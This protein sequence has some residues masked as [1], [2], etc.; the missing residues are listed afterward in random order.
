MQIFI[1][2]ICSCSALAPIKI[3][4]CVF[5]NIHEK[6]VCT[7]IVFFSVMATY[8]SNEQA[9][10]SQLEPGW[11]P[12]VSLSFISFVAFPNCPLRILSQEL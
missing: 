5:F 6:L 10:L 7:D 8:P 4:L 11:L 3:L 9:K 2:K 12:I 1:R